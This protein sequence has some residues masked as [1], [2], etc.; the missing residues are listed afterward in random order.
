VSAAPD[1]LPRRPDRVR[2]VELLYSQ[3]CGASAEAHVLLRTILLERGI[4]AVL[5]LHEVRTQVEAD[6]LGLAGSPTIRVDGNDVDPAGA[7]RPN[8][9]GARSYRL[10]DGSLGRLPTRRQLEHALLSG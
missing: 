1:R 10:P 3:D 4:E 8:G 6:E 7:E 9:L 5:A 2:Y